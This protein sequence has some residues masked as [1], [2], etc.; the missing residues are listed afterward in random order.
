MF[1]PGLLFGVRWWQRVLR[2]VCLQHGSLWLWESQGQSSPQQPEG[3]RD[4]P[5]FCSPSWWNATA[6]SLRYTVTSPIYTF[7]LTAF[8]LISHSF[9]IL[10]CVSLFYSESAGCQ[11]SWVQQVWPIN[12][13]NSELLPQQQDAHLFP[14]NTHH[15]SSEVNTHTCMYIALYTGYVAY[16]MHLTH[17]QK[18]C[19]NN[20][21]TAWH[22]DNSQLSGVYL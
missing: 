15:Q 4:D 13:A 22:F 21:T 3:N 10:L 16:T 12:T 5:P 1:S 6:P 20:T 14:T 17:K 9:S 2:T 11:S 19:Y 7:P 18:Y 8:Y